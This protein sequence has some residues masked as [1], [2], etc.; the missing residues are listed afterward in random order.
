MRRRLWPALGVGFVIT[1]AL[2]MLI[3]MIMTMEKIIFSAG[4]TCYF[5]LILPMIW[6]LQRE[7]LLLMLD[8]FSTLGDMFHSMFDSKCIA[9]LISFGVMFILSSYFLH[10]TL[11]FIGYNKKRV[12]RRRERRSC[13]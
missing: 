1:I 3:F 12:T 7:S 2:M 11:R 8:F 13:L 5:K 10:L 6:A 4:S 9:S